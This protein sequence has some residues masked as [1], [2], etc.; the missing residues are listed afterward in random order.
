LW[1]LASF[2]RSQF[3]HSF[4][5]THSYILSDHRSVLLLCLAVS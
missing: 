5:T 3:T 2:V 1:F 4:F